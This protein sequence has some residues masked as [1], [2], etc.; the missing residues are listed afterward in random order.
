MGMELMDTKK[1]MAQLMREYPKL[2]PILAKKGI[3]CG[4]CLGSAV[5]TLEDV[6]RM[7][8]LDLQVLQEE[9]QGRST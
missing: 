6:A 1:N 2:A 9:L 4:D 5:D 8:N 7:Y 3:D